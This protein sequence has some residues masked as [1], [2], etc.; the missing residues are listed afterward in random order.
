MKNRKETHE[1]D[2]ILLAA[3]D[4]AFSGLGEPVKKSIYFHLERDF[5]VSKQEIPSRIDDFTNALEL[6]FGPGAKHLEILI[7]KSLCVKVNCSYKWQGPNWLVPNLTFKEYI[8]LA[9]ISH[10]EEREGNIEVIVD[11]GERQEQRK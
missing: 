9:K 10:E 1:F 5:H 11:A 7:M 2:I 4:E 8:E 3:I 6:I